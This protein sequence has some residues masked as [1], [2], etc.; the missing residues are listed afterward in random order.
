VINTAK[1]NPAMLWELKTIKQIIFV[2]KANQRAATALKESF[3]MQLGRIY[4]E[5]L[6]VYHLYSQFISAKIGSEGV[7]VTRTVQIRLMMTLKREILKLIKTFVDHCTDNENE[8]LLKS[9]LP[10]L[11]DPV[12]DDYKKNAP[13]ARES[14]V[15]MLFASFINRLKGGITAGVPRVFDSVFE[16]TLGKHLYLIF[17]L[18]LPCCV[19]FLSV[20]LGMITKNFED[21]PDHRLALFKLLQAV[22]VHCFQALLRLSGPQFGLVMDSIVWAIKH[23]E[24][25]IAD[26]GLTVL[27]DLIKNVETSEVANDFYKRYFISLCQ[28]LL[29]V[30][31]DTFHKPGRQ[32]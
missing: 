3:I 19:M 9:F 21:Y 13:D 10:A 17:C 32:L 8:P 29:T 12:L 6:Q 15:L 7:A 25:N 14:E 22:N 2:L 31:T 5:M 23:L 4:M 26:V 27:A 1:S 11:L 30:L 20:Y 16:A 28:D 18:L 24:R